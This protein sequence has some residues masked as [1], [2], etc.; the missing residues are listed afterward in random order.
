MKERSRARAHKNRKRPRKIGDLRLYV[1]DHTLKSVSAFAHLKEIC[2]E[3]LRGKYH[4][5]VIDIRKDPDIAKE[6][7]IVAIPTLVRRFPLPARTV[8]GDLSDTKRVL[9]ALQ[10]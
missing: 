4:L 8:I 10:L 7:Q 9:R 3:H 2:N 6:N 5:S 1:L